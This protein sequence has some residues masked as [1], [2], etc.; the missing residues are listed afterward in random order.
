MIAKSY[1]KKKSKSYYI[2]QG[3]KKNAVYKASQ[4]AS[5][6]TLLPTT[7]LHTSRRKKMSTPEHILHARTHHLLQPGTH[8]AVIMFRLNAELCALLSTLR[9]NLVE[10]EVILQ[11]GYALCVLTAFADK[12]GLEMPTS[13]Q[14]DTT[15]VPPFHET[16]KLPLTYLA[17]EFTKCQHRLNFNLAQYFRLTPNKVTLAY[18]IQP[19]L[20]RMMGLILKI[21]GAEHDYIFKNHQL[22]SRRRKPEEVILPPTWVFKVPRWYP[23]PTSPLV[24]APSTLPTST[25]TPLLPTGTMATEVIAEES[26]TPPL[27]T[28]TTSVEVVD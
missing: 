19:T 3:Q 26:S 28:Q 12:L 9:P 21:A 2:L 13:Y 17:E 4:N 24:T 23:R 18:H 11:A 20:I 8:L 5:L 22:H 6:H 1:F 7:G 15:E 27:P 10:S 16:Q 14:Q 25:P